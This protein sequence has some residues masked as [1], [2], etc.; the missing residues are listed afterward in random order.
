MKTINTKTDNDQFF[1]YF[2]VFTILEII[3]FGTEKSWIFWGL[4]MVMLLI[5]LMGDRK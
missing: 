1:T 3:Y 2:I 5:F 4:S